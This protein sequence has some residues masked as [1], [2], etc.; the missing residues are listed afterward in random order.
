[1]AK[2]QLQSHQPCRQINLPPRTVGGVSI[3]AFSP[4]SLNALGD[5]GLGGGLGLPCEPATPH[6]PRQ[7]PEP[8]SRAD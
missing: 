6:Q 1:M 2:R 8:S 4:A 7:R 3:V 5:Q